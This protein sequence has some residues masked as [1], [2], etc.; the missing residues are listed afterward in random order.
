MLRVLANVGFD[1]PTTLTFLAF[2]GNDK[3]NIRSVSRMVWIV[4]LR[5]I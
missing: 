2:G 3:N 5:N 4:S 1:M